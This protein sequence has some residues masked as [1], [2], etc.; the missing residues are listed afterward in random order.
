MLSAALYARVRLTTLLHARPRVQ[1]APG[2]PCALLMRE[3]R[4]LLSNLGRFPPRDRE[5]IFGG[6]HVV[7]SE[8]DHC[9]TMD[10]E[11]SGTRN[12]RSCE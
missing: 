6:N 5:I 3:V 10:A 2:I 9:H 7:A 1:R 8:A 4:K 12:K 11:A